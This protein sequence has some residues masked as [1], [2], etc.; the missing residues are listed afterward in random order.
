M[1]PH[2]ITHCINDDTSFLRESHH[3]RD[4]KYRILMNIKFYASQGVCLVKQLS[5]LQKKPLNVIYTSKYQT[6]PAK[7]KLAS[8]YLAGPPCICLTLASYGQQ[9][10]FTIW[11]PSAILN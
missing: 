2:T 7:C 10:R 9:R 5:H 8:L 3:S 1:A 11:R 6:L 4:I